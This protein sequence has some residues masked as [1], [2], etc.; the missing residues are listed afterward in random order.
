MRDF[1]CATAFN[2]NGSFIAAIETTLVS[3]L[4]TQQPQIAVSRKPF[5]HTALREPRHQPPSQGQ[6]IG[7]TKWLR[8]ANRENRRYKLWDA[9]HSEC[10]R[11]NTLHTGVRTQT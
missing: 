3:V 8:D 6:D 9:T 7:K 10:A 4:E 2:P 11:N 5:F 1:N